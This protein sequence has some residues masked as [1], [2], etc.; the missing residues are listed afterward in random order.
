MISY[1]WREENAEQQALAAKREDLEKKQQ[2]L[3]AATGKVGRFFLLL[4]FTL[5]HLSSNKNLLTLKLSV[6]HWFPV[7]NKSRVQITYPLNMK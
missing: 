4:Q 1:L 5:S 3:R 6:G 7:T 2:L